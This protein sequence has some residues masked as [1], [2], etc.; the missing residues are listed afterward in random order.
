L[1]PPLGR[2][3]GLDYRVPAH[4]GRV[5]AGTRVLVPL[6]GRRSMGVVV[7]SVE[8]GDDA[9]ASRLRDVVAVLDPSPLLDA[10]LLELIEWM[11]DYYVAPLAEA[12]TTALP[13][14]LRVQTERVASAVE[15][16]TPSIDSKG[17]RERLLAH[18]HGEGAQSIAA[19]ERRFGD[20]TQSALRRLAREGAVR[21]A[22]RMRREHAP[23][24]HAIHYQA[25]GTVD[26]TVL[27]R[28]PALAAL[29]RYLR[30][31]P[32]GGASARELRTSFPNAAAKLRALTAAGLVRERREEIYREILP[33]VPG[34]DRPVTLTDAQQ[35]AVGA[36]S[37][38]FESGFVSFLLRG[39]TG[40]GKTEV[41]L[42]AIAGARQRG[43][44]AL[45]L[46]PEISLT[47]QIVDR[48]RARFADPVAVLHSKLSNGER[49]DQW[50]RIARGEAPIVIGARSAVFAPL[51]K[52]GL[53][54]VDEEHDAAYKQ[55]DGVHYHGRDV[56]VMRAK[57]EGCPLILGSA[58]PSMESYAN[59]QGGRYRLVELPE[60]V[61]SRPLPR[62]EI[63]DVRG[64]GPPP[65]LSLVL[66][67]A[68]EANLAAGGQTLLFLNRRGFAHF[69]Q[70]R[71]C[72]EPVMCPNCS[73]SLTWHRRWRAL[74]CHH[75]D[76]TVPPPLLCGTC[77]E[78]A[79]Q[80]W[81]VGTEQLETLLRERFPGARI[82]R[83]DRDSTRRK[84]SLEAVLA[85]WAAGHLD[86]LI[87]TQMITKGHDV[88]GVT[89]V[90][91]LLADLSLAFPDFRAAERT[92]QL[93]A[94]VAGRAG[95][96]DKPGRVIVQTLQPD[97][98]SLGAAA[99]H[100]FVGFAARELAARR[101]LGYPPYGRL[102]LVR[103]EGEALADVDRT[104]GEVAAA[105]QQMAKGF[106]VLGPAPSPIER[107]RGRHRRQILLRGK[108][109]AP[110]RRAAAAAVAEVGQTARSRAVRL[111]V[112]VDP[113]HML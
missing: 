17:V 69:L 96:G 30:D 15:P 34:P 104:A 94:Q 39:A 68:M 51:E 55:A 61:A 32:L 45:V 100:D 8:A 3:A 14:A 20:G 81:G 105:L 7:A 103:C 107:L 25:S 66:H 9:P 10:K 95:R 75:C 2:L 29:Y 46:V 65:P 36:V 91:V 50:R 56:A 60:R 77:G 23:T 98:Y 59:A 21:F 16:L 47:H 102:V 70:C 28:R 27:D 24:L 48:V 33:P 54:V 52:L 79:L 40:S 1:V 4:F 12:V 71:A 63:L 108:A 22:E 19:L 43:R 6:G 85:A 106:A 110:L 84:G 76:H 112:D 49:W 101:E 58:T 97:H 73:V 99:Q 109:G 72:G 88:P 31:H 44:T 57:L 64:P 92:F 26:D 53:I 37:S 93:L 113:Q 42:R 78:P 62:V 11:A 18:L 41:Y 83:V 5:R 13:G 111:I 80:E 38:A 90:G 82:A 86:V 89:L 35:A 74:R 67:A 87:G